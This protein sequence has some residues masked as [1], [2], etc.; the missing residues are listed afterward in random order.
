MSDRQD[1][2]VEWRALERKLTG[3][4]R[5]APRNAMRA[6]ATSAFRVVDSE[7]ARSVRETQ[8]KTPDHRPAFRRRAAT[9]GG[10]RYK[11]RQRRDGSLTADSAYQKASK[12][13]EL[14]HAYL[15]ERGWKTKTGNV[16]GRHLRAEAFKAKHRAAQARMV[17][18][19]RV[20]IDLA[21]NHPR[22]L[23]RIGD[24]ERTVGGWTA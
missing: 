1:Y 18:A 10:Y 4:E 3:L 8:W 7:N 22:G 23:V 11:I 12:Y 16:P 14:W 21:A 13:P 6:A 5:Y 2:T 19:V 24:V 9:R 20:A 17:H 15:V